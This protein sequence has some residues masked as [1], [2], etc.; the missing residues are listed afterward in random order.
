LAAAA[1]EAAVFLVDV[2]R[3]RA[4]VVRLRAP[5]ADLE[6][7]DEPPLEAEEAVPVPSLSVTVSSLSA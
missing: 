3:R 1:P 5:P 4:V 7:P 2:L 6:A